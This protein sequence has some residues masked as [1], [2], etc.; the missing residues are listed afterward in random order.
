M[1]RLG[2]SVI[3]FASSSVSRAGDAYEETLEDTAKMVEKYADIV[4][5]RHP[6][7]G[8]AIRFLR[9]CEIPV[10]NAGDGDNEHPTQAILDLYTI[11]RERGRID[12]ATILMLGDLNFRAVHSLGYALSKFKDIKLY[13]CSPE[14]QKLPEY[15]EK[16]YK[17]AGLNFETVNKLEDVIKET[18]IIYMLASTRNRS[19]LPA[20]YQY[21]LEPKKLANAK[22]NILILHQLPRLDELPVLIDQMK[23]S[24]Y[25]TTEPM[26]GVVVRMAILS[27]LLSES[28]KNL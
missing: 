1:Q 8:A 21:R 11:R 5:I 14:Y 3:G 15:Y 18:D 22:E 19:K 6:Q 23:Q 4:V 9:A 28:H 2:G 24:K 27:L 7:E 20:D 12:G 13:L 16:H 26:S 17:A 25:L 10:V